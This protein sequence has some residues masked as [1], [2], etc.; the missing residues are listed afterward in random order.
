M[1]K[2]TPAEVTAAKKLSSLDPEIHFDLGNVAF[3]TRNKHFVNTA[4][5]WS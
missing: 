3:M 1:V 4:F 2:A 5:L